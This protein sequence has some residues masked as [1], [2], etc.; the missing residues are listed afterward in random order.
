M[1]NNYTYPYQWQVG[2]VVR[3]RHETSD[4]Q[5]RVTGFV[6]RGGSLT[7][8]LVCFVELDRH[9]GEQRAL[10]ESQFSETYEDVTGSVTERI[11]PRGPLAAAIADME[12][13]IAAMNAQLENMRR[14]ARGE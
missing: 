9:P 1:L 3:S 10:P 7:E 12:A 4:M 11:R 8:R 6:T 13:A 5:Y 14:I 2:T